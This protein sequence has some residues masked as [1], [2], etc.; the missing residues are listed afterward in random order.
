M[1]SAYM[2]DWSLLDWV[3]LRI[4]PGLS[5]CT[6]AAPRRHRA[7]H[8]VQHLKAVFESVDLIGAERR[9]Q[10]LEARGELI[11][12]LI[13]NIFSGGGQLNVHAPPVELAGHA[14]D[15]SA[16]LEPVDQPSDNRRGH[17]QAARD[18]TEGGFRT[19]DVLERAQLTQAQVVIFI[20]C[21][22][23]L[24]PAAEPW[25]EAKRDVCY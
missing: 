3:R 22:L 19:V 20:V 13:A 10:R 25:C 23:G 18:I 16:A 6:L 12:G 17:I 1:S 2:L 21:H 24:D 15:V 14:A 8:L 11:F 7:D 5:R 9:H 4:E